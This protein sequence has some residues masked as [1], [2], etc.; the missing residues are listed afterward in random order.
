MPGTAGVLNRLAGL[1]VPVYRVRLGDALDVALREPEVA[2][3]R[4]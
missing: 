2:V 1:R 4:R 3:A